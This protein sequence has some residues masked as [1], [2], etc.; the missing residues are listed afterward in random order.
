M[1]FRKLRSGHI[2]KEG[3]A[4][5][6]PPTPI[7]IVFNLGREVLKDKRVREAVSL[8]F[9]F[10]WTNESL[11]YGLFKQRASFTQDT[12]LMATGVPEGAELEFLQCLG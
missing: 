5:G 7:G 9:N 11:Q 4:D 6:A 12:P 2:V 3:I 8:G 10:E 1:I